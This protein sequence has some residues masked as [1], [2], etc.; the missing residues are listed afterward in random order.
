MKVLFERSKEHS[1]L[2]LAELLACLDVEIK[3][4]TMLDQN[5]DVLLIETKSNEQNL[6]VL[7]G[8]LAFTFVIDE[9]LF[10]CPAALTALIEQAARNPVLQEG[11]IAIRCKNRGSSLDSAQVIDCLGDVYTKQ[12]VVDLAHPA[13]EVRAVITANTTYVGV[14]KEEINTSHFQQRRGHLRPFLSPVT[15]HPKIARALVNLACLKKNDVVLDPFCGT[16]GI[17][18]EA[19]LIGMRII[20]SD[21]EQKMIEGCRSNLRFYQLKD[22]ALYRTDIGDIVKHVSSVDAV[23]TDFPY[24]KATTT[25][26]EEPRLLYDRGFAVIS[27]VLRRD[28]RAVVG[29]ANEEMISLGEKHMKL[30]NVYP[31]RA[32]RSLTRFF[33]VYQKK[34]C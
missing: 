32:H 11:T 27:R 31:I 1:A 5:E 9:L 30:L 13:V 29:L 17:L 7:A 6:G 28:G 33:A 4:Y 16:G 15:M 22:Y 8:R 10:S 18:I 14:K 34:S 26:G 25:R 20:G 3:T 19:G 12:R 23:V 24:A 21:V 2:S